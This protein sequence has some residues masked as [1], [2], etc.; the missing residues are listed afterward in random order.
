[1]AEETTSAKSRKVNPEKEMTFWEHL[2]ELRSVLLRSSLVIVIIGIVAFINRK[3]I[4]DTIILGPKDSD[5]I[6]NRLLC[7]AA[8]L[9]SIK[10]LCRDDLAVNLV[11]INMSGQFMIHMYASIVAAVVVAIPYILWEFW[12]FIRPAL[13]PKEKKYSRG[14]VMV[15]SVL[16]LTGVAFGYFLIVPLAINFFATYQVS[17]AVKN[18]ITLS[19]YISTVVST[20]VACGIVF[21]LPI[22]VYFLTKV[23]IITPRLMIKSRKYML[24][25]LLTIAAIITPP[26]VF[27]QILV[28]IPLMGLYELSIFVS[29]RVYKAKQKKELAG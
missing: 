21:E 18:T 27:S 11:N 15:S 8:N 14:A 5:F 3:F 25:I 13:L 28:T 6:T 19:S 4:F 20:T 23:G 17:E 26:D 10:G 16:F 9:L 1:M 7:K 24:V 22:I 2:E 12:R 29:K